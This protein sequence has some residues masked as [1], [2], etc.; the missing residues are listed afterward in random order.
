M[1]SAFFFKC[2]STN[3][4]IHIYIMLIG[5]KVLDHKA[6]QLKPSRGFQISNLKRYIF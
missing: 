5:L 2:E 4:T 3:T 1:L 6:N